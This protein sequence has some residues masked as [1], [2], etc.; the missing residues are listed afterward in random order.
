MATRGNIGRKQAKEILIEARLVNADGLAAAEKETLKS[1]RP[2]QQIVVDLKLADKVDVLQALSREWRTK[3]VDLAEME[4]DPEVV[5]ILPESTARKSLVLPFAKEDQVLLVAMADPRDF[6]V[7]E[8]IHLRTG[9]EVQRYLAMP[10]DIL[11]ELDKVYGVGAAGKAEELLKSVTDSAIPEGEGLERIQEKSDVTEVDASAPEVEKIVN[12]VIL[13]A[14]QM[15]ASDIHIEPFEDPAGKHSKILVRFR[16]DGF[17]RM[18]NFQVPWMYRAAV[19]AKIK[20]MTNT[21][22]ITERRIP[23]SGRI[24]VMAKGNPIDF[25]VEIIP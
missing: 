9:L 16:V 12:A 24:Q 15:K 13:S 2:L 14:L 3:A 8:D 23:Q 21:M 10:E 1:D 11:K 22:N 5:R 25:R 4:I 19:M 20:I 6:L 18:A 17:L 7:S